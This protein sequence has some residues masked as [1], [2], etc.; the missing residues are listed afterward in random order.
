[1]RKPVEKRN[2]RSLVTETRV[3]VWCKSENCTKREEEVGECLRR[4][5]ELLERKM[6]C[7]K[8]L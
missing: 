3:F 5:H 7:M 8:V 2:S 6:K 4:G 1:M